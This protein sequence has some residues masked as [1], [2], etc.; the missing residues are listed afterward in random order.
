MRK[1]YIILALILFVGLGCLSWYAFRKGKAE[2]KTEI[3]NA[4]VEAKT[5]DRKD[6]DLKPRYKFEQQTLPGMFFP[7]EQNRINFINALMERKDALVGQLLVFAYSKSKDGCPYIDAKFSVSSKVIRVHDDVPEF[8]VI[9][10]K[11]PEPEEETLASRI[12][13][14]IG[15]SYENPAY[16]LVEKSL[17]SLYVLCEINEEWAHLTYGIVPEGE[18]EQLEEVCYHYI[19]H[20]KA[21]AENNKTQGD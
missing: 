13:L 3:L 12:F 2:T 18:N 14:C 19:Q 20:L 11:M 8:G 1:V 9:I 5:A 7:N 16:Y 17:G 10:I 21:I 4:E 15:K 6:Y